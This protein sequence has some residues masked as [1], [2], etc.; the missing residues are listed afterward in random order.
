M[1]HASCLNDGTFAMSPARLRSG[2]DSSAAVPRISR[3]GS[4]LFMA[5]PYTSAE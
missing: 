3:I 2:T 4:T 5:E 1:A